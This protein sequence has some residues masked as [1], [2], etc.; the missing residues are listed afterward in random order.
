MKPKSVVILFAALIAAVLVYAL[1]YKDRL[2]V[3]IVTPDDYIRGAVFQLHAEY[4]IDGEAVPV[5]LE[6]R[7]LADEL[8][9]ELQLPSR[10][11]WSLNALRVELKHPRYKPTM[12]VVT[13]NP[14]WFRQDL[15]LEPTQ[16]TTNDRRTYVEP[17]YETSK[18]ALEHLRWVRTEYFAR[19]EWLAVNETVQA[20]P[21]LLGSMAYAGGSKDGEWERVR[22]QTIAEWKSLKGVLDERIYE[23]CP[24]GY[25]VEDMNYPP[26]GKQRV[27]IVYLEPAA[28]E[29]EDQSSRWN[30]GSQISHARADLARRLEVEV[31]TVRFAGYQ[32]MIWRSDALGC[33]D[34]GESY[35]EEEITGYYMAFT[36]AHGGVH[37]YHGRADSAPFYCPEDRQTY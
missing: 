30:E 20:D 21:Q 36:I 32:P 26:C 31:D 6:D 29:P 33:P 22:Q 34:D 13:G 17:S 7:L 23:P 10:A 2:T 28:R 27:N 15:E 4:E 16:W 35:T 18:A 19:S 5:V 24:D 9:F 14:H 1:L 8:Y 37:Y 12:A 25:E 3:R 11:P